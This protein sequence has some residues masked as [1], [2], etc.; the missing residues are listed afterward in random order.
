MRK[1][2]A[3]LLS[4]MALAG[5]GQTLD[6]RN[7]EISSNTVYEKGANEPYSG[8]LTNVPLGVAPS[9]KIGELLK[10]AGDATQDRSVAGTL[11]G[12]GIAQL[13][14]AGGGEAVVA[15]NVEVNDGKLEGQASCHFTRTGA[16]V[17]EYTY[18]GGT[19][20]GDLK[21]YSA[22]H[23][24]KL[25][26]EAALDESGV[27]QGE[28]KVYNPETGNLLATGN[29][30]DGKLD[31]ELIGYDRETGELV[32]KGR[33]VDGLLEGEFLTYSPDGDTLIKKQIFRAGKLH[34]SVEEYDADGGV[35]KNTTFENG[36]DIDLLA[37]YRREAEALI[38]AGREGSL[39]WTIESVRR[40]RECIA[41][42]QSDPNETRTQQEIE[43][44]CE[45]ETPETVSAE[46]ERR[47]AEDRAW[48]QQD[49]EADVEGTSA[50]VSQTGGDAGS[51]MPSFNCANASSRVELMICGNP[52]LAQ[53]DANL[54]QAY[55]QT[56]ACAADKARVRAAQRTWVTN[57]NA[58]A[59]EACVANEYEIRSNRLAEECAG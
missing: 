19:P 39:E 24:G 50:D 37:S 40:S 7:A 30:K 26:I 41:R 32:R 12:A 11:F 53:A 57:R 21:V 13:L 22:K 23:E 42:Q 54:A 38:A 25:L 44:A 48:A 8:S 18:I 51:A 20:T 17:Y 9:P 45:L 33:A 10:F 31:G 1:V 15:C 43:A 59:D 2:G 58:C 52:Q 36:Q 5:C 35:V 56:I 16:P 27:V 55:R 46:K 4:T 14:G 6:F 3:L 49:A 47:A 28:S 29:W 34:G